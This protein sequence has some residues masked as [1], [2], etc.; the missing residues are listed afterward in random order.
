MHLQ[1]PN[2]TKSVDYYGLTA[3]INDV[4]PMGLHRVYW[5]VSDN[6]GNVA[7][8]N[9]WVQL[10]DCK[11]KSGMFQRIGYSNAGSGNDYSTCKIFQPQVI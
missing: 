7:S 4:L 8:G 5:T 2:G 1:N 10:R 3:T 6:C 9:Y 11:T